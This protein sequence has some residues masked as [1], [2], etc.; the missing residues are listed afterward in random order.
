MCHS[1]AELETVLCKMDK[2]KI[3]VKAKISVHCQS[4]SVYT[5]NQ[6]ASVHVD[7]VLGSMESSGAV[8]KLKDIDLALKVNDMF[9]LNQN[10]I[11]KFILCVF[12]ITECFI[13]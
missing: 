10:A 13:Y 3:K 1:L 11:C 7:V 5:E 2:L 4:D 9:P 12:N 6:M 8:L